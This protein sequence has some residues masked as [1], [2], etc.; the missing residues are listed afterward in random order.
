MNR[1]LKTAIF[2]I[3]STSIQGCAGV[4]T[5]TSESVRLTN[6][7]PSETRGY[8]VKA[9]LKT[10]TTTKKSIIAY[11]GSPDKATIRNS[12]EILEYNVGSS[13]WWGITPV[14]IIPIPLLIPGGQDKITLVFKEEQLAEVVLTGKAEG[15]HLCGIMFFGPGGPT[16]PG[17]LSQTENLLNKYI[18]TGRQCGSR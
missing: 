14:F 13:Y 6:A 1:V 16:G 15:E 4:L 12:Y 3:F 7:A 5:S 10:A 2:I 18:K 17:C 11:W 8:F 9:N